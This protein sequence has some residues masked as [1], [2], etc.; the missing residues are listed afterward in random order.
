M[1]KEAQKSRIQTLEKL[2]TEASEAKLK[3]VK[4]GAQDSDD[5]DEDNGEGD[6]APENPEDHPSI[7]NDEATLAMFGSA[8]SVVVDENP[9]VNQ[10][11]VEDFDDNASV[12]S[13]RSLKSSKNQNKAPQLSRFD[14]AMKKVKDDISSGKLA[15]KNNKRPNL[16]HAKEQAKKS[17]HA[18][19]KKGTETKKLFEKAMGRKMKK[20]RGKK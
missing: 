18:L 16:F 9:V 1:R 15:R 11:S 7:F 3:K 12:A 19:Q 13:L 10:F 5:E 20:G 17:G 14:R 8:V 4:L 6:V 2:N